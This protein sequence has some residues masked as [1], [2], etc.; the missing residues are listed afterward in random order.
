MLKDS[1]TKAEVAELMRGTPQ[2]G[3][4]EVRMKD[5]KR[6]GSVTLRDYFHEDENGS[7][8]ERP[9]I[10]A[11]GNHRVIKY[12]KKK[13]LRMENENDRL[14]YAHLKLHPIYVN[15]SNPVLILY[16]FDDEA[17]TYVGNKDA[18]SKADSFIT[19]LDFSKLQDLARVMQIK[20][21]PGSSEIVLKRALYEYAESKLGA[22][23]RLGALDIL[24]QI[25]S[26]DY[27]RKVLLYKAIE[28][29]T[30][31]IKNGRYLF[32]QVGMGTTFDVS[33]QFL[34][35]NPD[36]ESELAKKMNV[37]KL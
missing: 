33:L 29:K 4:I 16:N 15:G 34:K 37:K 26:P 18:S 19:K 24:E 12:T 10:D 20:V 3:T 22:N 28:N 6:T 32:N 27:D 7:R 36:M 13:L 23:N 11:N 1:Y 31:E 9:L 17:K 2:S 30:V 25:E 8:E 35:D 14:E 21:R 5:P